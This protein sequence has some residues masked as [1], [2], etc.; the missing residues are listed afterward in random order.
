[1]SGVIS[2]YDLV[3]GM[4]VRKDTQ[5]VDEI[6]KSNDE[7]RNS[8]ENQSRF[9]NARKVATIP[10]VV[11]E[12]LKLR[13]HKDGGPIDINLVGTD[14]DHTVRFIRWLDD[15]DNLKFRTSEARLGDG[16]KYIQ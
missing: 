16:T 1:M 2:E 8:G 12:A 6:I 7:E 13:S 11:L 10:V 4:F 15:R 3:D 14:P 9:S 5:D